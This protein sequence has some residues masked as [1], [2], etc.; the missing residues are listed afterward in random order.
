MQN[1]ANTIDLN[2][3]L[4]ARQRGLFA[5]LP[6]AMLAVNKK[7]KIITQ[8]L[9]GLFF[10]R[11]MDALFKSADKTKPPLDTQAFNDLRIF[12]GQETSFTQQF[13][14]ALDV[15]YAELLAATLGAEAEAP[16]ID[17][18]LQ[19]LIDES[20][21]NCLASNNVV[22]AGID[23][24]LGFL[25][26]KKITKSN[27]LNP[28]TLSRLFNQ[29]AARLPISESSLA[30]I[31]PIFN[32]LFFDHLGN[33]YS[34]VEEQLDQYNVPK[35]KA[36]DN[37]FSGKY[38]TLLSRRNKRA[39]SENDKETV[40]II[41]NVLGDAANHEFFSHQERLKI[42]DAAQQHIRQ[43]SAPLSPSGVLKQLQ[44]I[45]QQLG[46]H[47]K[48]SPHD[49]ELI[50]LVSVMFDLVTRNPSLDKIVKNYLIRLLIPMV[51]ISLIDHG[52]FSDSRHPA[53][54]LLNELVIA[55]LGW[56]YQQDKDQQHPVI[57]QID[58]LTLEVAQN[59]TC[60][61]SV[62]MAVLIK[63]RKSKE[64]DDHELSLLNA[65]LNNYS[66]GKTKANDA[67]SLA[68]TAIKNILEQRIA[69]PIVRV[70]ARQLWQKVLA[71]IALKYSVHSAEWK[72][73]TDLLERLC[74]LATPCT[75]QKDK[76]SRC[77]YLPTFIP[78]LQQCL[79]I[80][81]YNA[82]DAAEIFEEIHH[83]L[84]LCLKGQAPSEAFRLKNT[85][86]TEA[87]APGSVERASNRY[88]E[89]SP[90]SDLGNT[91]R[92]KGRNKN[93][94]AAQT[95]DIDIEALNTNTLNSTIKNQPT[96][97]VPA[98]SKA[99]ST[100]TVSAVA[101]T[102]EPT[103]T[104]Q[105]ALDINAEIQVKIEK[106]ARGA[107]FDYDELGTGTIRCRLAAVIKQTNSFIFINRNGIKVAE[108]HI[109]EVIQAIKNRQLL[110]IEHGMVFDKALEA[111]VTGLRRSNNNMMDNGPL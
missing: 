44:K 7:Q 70:F 25:L 97:N 102:A 76:I 62:F 36:I 95:I 66:N 85:H 80:C 9:L 18:A 5:R 89:Y 23:T 74:Q 78:R 61:T 98:A 88:D 27:P 29:Q 69:A 107:L 33:I 86:T 90:H 71:V 48:F 91:Q 58:A 34:A 96:A 40:R 84:C 110:P 14:G 64:R 2:P 60:D 75:S 111:V 47:G 57:K 100:S 20:V 109:S 45:Q 6:P 43:T 106:F 30:L 52:F 49:N 55:G 105:T 94:D 101:A 35:A 38:I 59:L 39:I 37:H 32:S 79:C 73:H 11:S 42:L 87:P 16:S 51:K 50:K 10:E 12:R 19:V 13:L 72:E 8:I 24:R 17:I 54:Y 93:N 77:Q 41:E 53:R 92:I 22:L 65:R 46:I 81:A 104:E 67:D 83:T 99:T 68:E 15:S 63:L 3:A 21:N 103:A 26:N 108:L 28:E 4:T 31:I 56:Q 1:T 82:F